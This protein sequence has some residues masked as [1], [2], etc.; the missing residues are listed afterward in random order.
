MFVE[1]KIGPSLITLVP[2]GQGREPIVI[3]SYFE[4]LALT[5]K[6]CDALRAF[7]EHNGRAI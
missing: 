1:V 5:Y 3:R 4:A 6:L 2:E 7:P